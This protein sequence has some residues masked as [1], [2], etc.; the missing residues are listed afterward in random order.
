MNWQNFKELLS[1]NDG[2]AL[3]FE[4]AP[5]QW[6][7]ASY[8]ITEIKQAQI[9]SVDCGGKMN[10]WTEV[11]V[12]LWLP[13]KRNESTPMSAAKALKI[14]DLVEKSLPIH[15]QAP[16]KIE[17]G[18]ED[19]PTRQLLIENMGVGEKGLEVSLVADK[20]QCKE[21]ERGGSCGPV[22]KPK[23]QLVSLGAAGEESVEGASCSPGSGC[24]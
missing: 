17:Y 4:Y 13:E 9:T 10:A 24:C 5:S 23:I 14:I 3:Q 18:D 7:D 2:A 19:F 11:V 15:P 21:N 6:V 1:Q 12:Q 22:E 20:T 8:H 16:V